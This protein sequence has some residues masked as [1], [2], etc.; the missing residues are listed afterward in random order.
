MNEDY[1]M[2]NLFN[3]KA[4]AAKSALVLALAAMSV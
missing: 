2:S 1:V 4:I 3:V